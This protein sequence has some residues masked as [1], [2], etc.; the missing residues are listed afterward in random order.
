MLSTKIEQVA[1]SFGKQI[2]DQ[3]P[4]LGISQRDGGDWLSITS[5]LG[6]GSHRPSLDDSRVISKHLADDLAEK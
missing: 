2:A 3:N 1:V 6:A 4:A 5:H